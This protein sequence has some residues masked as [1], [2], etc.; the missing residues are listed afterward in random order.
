MLRYGL[1][2]SVIRHLLS[3]Y[4]L[5]NC[6]IPQEKASLLLILLQIIARRAFGAVKGRDTPFVSLVDGSRPYLIPEI[7]ISPNIYFCNNDIY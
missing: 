6:V 7:S 5:V 4:Q 3:N 2:V 1:I